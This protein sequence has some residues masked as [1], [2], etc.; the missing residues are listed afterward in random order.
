MADH[1]RAEDGLKLQSLLEHPHED[2]DVEIKAWLDLKDKKHAADLAQALLAIAD[3]G[4][5]WVVIGFDEID[6]DWFPKA[7]VSDCLA[8]FT[9]DRI[10]GLVQ[11]YADPPFHCTVYPNSQL[12]NGSVHPVI[13][14]PGDHIVPIRSKRDG[15]N[16][17]HV[18][19][20]TYYT[21][22]PGPQSAPIPSARE[23]DVLLQRCLLAR[24]DELMQ[25]FGFLLNGPLP[26]VLEASTESAMDL[27]TRTCAERFG[28]LREKFPARARIYDHGYWTA[29]YSIVG[30][31]EAPSVKDLMNNVEA[32]KRR[33]TGWPMWV[34]LHRADLKPYPI[35]GDTVEAWLVTDE[36]R[37]PSVADFWR[38]S[39]KAQMYL[40]RGYE[41][42]E[43]AAHAGQALDFT[44]P[45]WR[46]AECL[47]HAEGMAAAWGVPSAEIAFRFTWLGLNGRTLASLYSPGRFIHPCVAK[48]DSAASSVT[49][50]ADEINV[51][52]AVIV[53]RV[54]EP[55]YSM[56]DFASFEQSVFDGVVA[57]FRGRRSRLDV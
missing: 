4:G 32:A 21:R 16:G 18:R 14:V 34:V 49:L 22:L 45:M 25:Q 5:G 42:D 57:E 56:F 8:L 28:S 11:S 39:R 47:L 43:E 46:T 33:E 26:K 30:A 23:W 10:N 2:I 13:R 17:Q 52:L 9:Q 12:S 24:R 1:E 15:P 20:N 38:A 51:N 54:L 55:L 6:G 44:I 19:A 31:P 35:D 27:W 7:D 29:A 41:G 48:T 53:R 37:H 50:R 36:E 40:V 3:Y